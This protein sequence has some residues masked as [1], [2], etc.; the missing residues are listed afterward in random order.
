MNQGT[1]GYSLTKK[2]EGRKS[3]DT[4]PL[5]EYLN[6]TFL[7]VAQA[8]LRILTACLLFVNVFFDKQ[9]I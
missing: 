7:F 8:M 3:C 2:T 6:L 4:V 9:I 5:M 1:Q